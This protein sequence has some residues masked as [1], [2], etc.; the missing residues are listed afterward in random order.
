MSPVVGVGSGVVDATAVALAAVVG[1]AV[2]NSGVGDGPAI[3][4]PAHADVTTAATT[5]D[6][7]RDR[8][9]W[10]WSQRD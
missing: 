8:S 10:I 5:S 7:R 2:V 3:G 1:V 6:A 4:D 9:M